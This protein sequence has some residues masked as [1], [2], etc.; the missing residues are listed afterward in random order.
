MFFWC[1]LFAEVIMFTYIGVILLPSMAFKYVALI[2]AVVLFFY[3]TANDMRENYDRLRDQVLEVLQKPA[4][5]ELEKA[6]LKTAQPNTIKRVSE[7]DGSFQIVIEKNSTSKKVLHH[8]DNITYLSRDLFDACIESCDPVRRQVC[9]IVVIAVLML[10]YILIAMWVKNVFHKEKEVSS[11]FI[12]A[13]T[14]AT[15][16]IPNLLQFLAH[17]SHFIKNDALVKQSV[18]KAIVEYANR[19]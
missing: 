17:R 1:Y 12:I 9:Y 16:F 5:L 14:T 3:K 13:Q 19:I 4:S 2:A 6:F 7:P 8:E 10:F 11:I 18:R 15:Y